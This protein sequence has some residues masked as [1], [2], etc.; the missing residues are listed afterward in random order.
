MVG[1]TTMVDNHIMSTIKEQMDRFKASDEAREA[2][3]LAGTSSHYIHTSSLLIVRQ[4][5]L[6]KYEGLLRDNANLKRDYESEM[7]IRRHYQTEKATKE[8]ELS[9]LQTQM[10]TTTHQCVLVD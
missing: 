4:D 10:V 6:Q 8:L 5:V 9:A 2:L 7:D 1:I 3:M